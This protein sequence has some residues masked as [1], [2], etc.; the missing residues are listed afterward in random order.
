MNQ[1]QGL[2]NVSYS[3]AH[4]EILKKND[5]ERVAKQ[6]ISIIQDSIPKKKLKTSEVLDIGCSS[7]VI[8][9]YLARHGRTVVG[10]DVDKNAIKEAIADS[11]DIKNLSYKLAGGTVLPCMV[12]LF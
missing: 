12:C 6:L 3:A 4:N 11:K 8:T 9:Q 10:T 7:G 5:R 2:G 1:T